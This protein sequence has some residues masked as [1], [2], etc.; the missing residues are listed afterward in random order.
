MALILGSFP[1]TEFP[2]Q[3][4]CHAAAGVHPSSRVVAATKNWSV[5]HTSNSQLFLVGPLYPFLDA[6]LQMHRV[7]GGTGLVSGLRVPLRVSLPAAGGL[8][9]PSPTG[10]ATGVSSRCC[11]TDTY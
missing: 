2:V 1:D 10:D 5:L 11:C 7:T 8:S 9:S 3:T 4:S 6:A